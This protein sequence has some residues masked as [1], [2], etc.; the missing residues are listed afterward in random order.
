M[1]VYKLIACLRIRYVAFF[2]PDFGPLTGNFDFRNNASRFGVHLDGSYKI[3]IFFRVSLLKLFAVEHNL[4]AV[5]RNACDAVAHEIDRIAVS[6]KLA[7]A[8]RGSLD[9]DAA[10]RRFGVRIPRQQTEICRSVHSEICR[11][12]LSHIV[13]RV[14]KSDIGNFRAR[15]KRGEQSAVFRLVR[16]IRCRNIFER[17]IVSDDFSRKFSANKIRGPFLIRKIQLLR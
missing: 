7:H 14:D 4:H 6:R 2:V 15:R 16:G 11:R 3:T 10:D 9:C 5:R 8:E 1:I 12:A 13:R 17:T